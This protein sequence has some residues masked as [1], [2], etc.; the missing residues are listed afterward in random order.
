M[1]LILTLVPLY[2]VQPVSASSDAVLLD[3]VPYVWQEING[4]C[5]WAAESVVLQYLGFDLTLHDLFAVSTIGFSWAY[6]KYQ[7][8]MLM[9]PG[10]IYQQVEPTKF[11]AD[12][13]GLNLTFYFDSEMAGIEEAQKLWEGQ[14]INIGLLDGE[15]QAFDLMR[16]TLDKGIP[17]ILSVDPSWLP[18]DDYDFLR[19]QGISGG[20]HGIVVVGYNDTNGIVTI[21]DPGVGSFG[22]N[23]GYPYDGRGNYTEMTYTA[24]NNAWKARSY[25]TTVFEPIGEPVEDVDSVLGP[26]VR[27]KLL[28]VGTTY[29]PYSSAAFIW[30]YGEAGFRQ[31]SSDMSVQGLNGYLSQFQDRDDAES[32][33]A[34]LLVFIGLGLESQ[35]TL[36]YLS[37]RTAIESLPKFITQHDLSEFVVKGS[38]ALQHFEALASNKSLI[39]PVNFTEHDSFPFNTFY[40]ISSAYNDTKNLEASLQLYSDELDQ[41]AEHLLGIADSWKAAGEVLAEIW[42]NDPFILYGPYLLIGGFGIGVVALYVIFRIKKKSS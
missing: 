2:A 28:G 37:Y 7:D 13:Y 8:T 38:D 9:Y 26:M 24:L 5:A 35:I 16:E 19:E 25:I 1:L 32:F 33:I 10:A 39:D 11:V 27:D 30:K 42:P 22:S 12:L 6:I 31:M 29:N 14:G 15:T 18:S 36:Q 34:S 17:L 3:G 4:F 21:I 20:G 23:F 40:N 41:I